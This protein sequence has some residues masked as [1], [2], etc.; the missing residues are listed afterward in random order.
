MF[1]IRAKYRVSAT[2][3]EAFRQD[4]GA[5]FYANKF[6]TMSDNNNAANRLTQSHGDSDDDNE[7]DLSSSSLGFPCNL[8]GGAHDFVD[9]FNN[10]LTSAPDSSMKDVGDEFAQ[11]WP[12]SLTPD[13][14]KGDYLV[15]GDR[16]KN[17]FDAATQDMSCSP[18]G[19]T[20]ARSASTSVLAAI[21]TT[22]VA[23][24]RR[25]SLPGAFRVSRAGATPPGADADDE[26][27]LQ[28]TDENS[29]V[30]SE[31]C[32]RDAQEILIEATLV[33][34][35][36]Q[37]T[38]EMPRRSNHSSVVHHIAPPQESMALVEAIPLY[39]IYLCYN[40]L[41]NWKS[42][43][44]VTLI[45]FAIAGV[46]V[47][48]ERNRQMS[49]IGEVAKVEPPMTLIEPTPL[50]TFEPTGLS[51]GGV[52]GWT[53]I[54]QE[55]DDGSTSQESAPP[56]VANST[57]TPTATFH[58]PLP[59]Y[60]VLSFQDPSSPQSRAYAWIDQD[61]KRE[62]YSTNKLL[63]RF[64]LATLYYSLHDRNS[65]WGVNSGAGWLSYGTDECE[66]QNST[67]PKEEVCSSGG[68]Y[69]HLSVRADWPGS[70]TGSLPRELWM[71]TSLL[72]IHLFAHNVGGELSD[73]VR[74][75]THLK[76]LKLL[77]LSL[78]GAVP[79]GV[80]ELQQLTSLELQKNELTLLPTELGELKKLQYLYLEENDFSTPLPSEL[81][82][83][84]NLRELVCHS[85]SLTGAVPSELASLPK[86]ETV[87]LSNNLLTGSDVFVSL[88]SPTLRLL[89]LGD[90]LL[91]GSLE[92]IGHLTGA[93]SIDLFGNNFSGSLPDELGNLLNVSTLLLD[94]TSVTGTI[95]KSLANLT[96]L[97]VLWLHNTNLHGS[98]PDELCR[99]RQTQE[100][101]LSID[102]GKVY[103]ACDCTCDLSS[104][105]A[106]PALINVTAP[107]P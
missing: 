62:N 40:T 64:A 68:E 53:T 70:P 27:S 107:L 52:E 35:Q 81:G 10:D 94:S 98:V 79:T 17:P 69:L 96:N 4:S 43:C 82:Q 100:I 19:T 67:T 41:G 92:G 49:Q 58:L 88:T 78:T 89:E 73:E 31:F 26:Y 42:I 22:L 23:A 85:S 9:I 59:S 84:D 99:L 95:P 45:I 32:T 93:V 28:M 80:R 34:D 72:S 71:L 11:S 5:H 44:F 91:S 86:L 102:C 7:T 39:R 24:Y 55:S 76:E 29:N 38:N 66:W 1:Q 3:R 18:T 83:L 33:C 101:D 13:A 105:Y 60:T 77:D 51:L 87:H 57:S 54:D 30:G 21:P 48:I 74:K 106:G 75:L 16:A 15:D 50:P 2:I 8:E 36:S 14:C 46:A 103:C 56:S 12:L 20:E 65:S 97:S 63:Q 47:I 61:P 37:S 104:T 6:A 25:E 90:N